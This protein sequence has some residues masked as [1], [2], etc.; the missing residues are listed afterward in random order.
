[1]IQLSDI[2]AALARIRYSILL[3]PCGISQPFS[4]STGNSVFLKLENHQVTGAFKERGA[5]NKILLLSDT[6]RSKGL[7][8]ASA[9]NHAQAVAYHASR[10]GV[11]SEIWMPSAPRFAKVSSPRG[12]GRKS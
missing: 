10:S 3:S 4:Q 1:M 5:L 8:A 11:R 6:D 12:T 9:G 7:I 2:Q